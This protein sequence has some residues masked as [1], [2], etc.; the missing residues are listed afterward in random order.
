ML[1]KQLGCLTV[2]FAELQAVFIDEAETI[3][4]IETERI[5]LGTSE[6]PWLKE[7]NSIIV[8]DG[9]NAKTNSSYEFWVEENPST[10]YVWELVRDWNGFF[11]V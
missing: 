3:D 9:Y 5:P 11:T 4:A 6:R 2:M 10:G 8:K 7:F 1:A